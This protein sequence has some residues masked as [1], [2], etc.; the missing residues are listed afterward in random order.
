MLVDPFL[1]VGNANH[2]QATGVWDQLCDLKEMV[3]EPRQTGVVFD[4]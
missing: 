2:T 4:A 1:L 3:A